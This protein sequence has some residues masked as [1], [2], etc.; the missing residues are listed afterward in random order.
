MS[1]DNIIIAHLEN[2]EQTNVLKTILIALKIKFEIQIK[3]KPYDSE[4]VK[5]IKKSKKEFN[6]GDFKAISTNDLWK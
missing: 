2:E 6:D 5:K 4:F 3:E 1:T